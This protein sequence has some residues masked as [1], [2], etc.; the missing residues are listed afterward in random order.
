M[1]GSVQYSNVHKVKSEIL[2]AKAAEK[3]SSTSGN[4]WESG[5]IGSTV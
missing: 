5:T 3:R 1:E 2:R 4:L